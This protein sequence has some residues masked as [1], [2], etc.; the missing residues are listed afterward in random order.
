[1]PDPIGKTGASSA[2]IQRNIR[3]SQHPQ[4]S[5]VSNE[6]LANSPASGVS[7]CNNDE[8][9]S[10]FDLDPHL[11]PGYNH[12]PN[13][14]VVS[15]KSKIFIGLKH[16]YMYY[17]KLKNVSNNA[18][19]LSILER[20][21]TTLSKDLSPYIAT[22]DDIKEIHKELQNIDKRKFPYAEYKQVLY[23]ISKL[24]FGRSENEVES[25]TNKK[26]GSHTKLN[27]IIGTV[28]FSRNQDG[29][30]GHYIM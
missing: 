26:G 1:M 4:S 5:N 9:K 11:L 2:L 12:Y 13:K 17:K 14:E 6:F 30:V 8:D 27:L 25:L 23:K 19:Q 28:N 3:S 24:N 7:H 18:G 16:Q 22:V 29:Y 21:L 10:P 20:H 15:F